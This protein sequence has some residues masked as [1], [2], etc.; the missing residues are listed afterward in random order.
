MGALTIVFCGFVI[1]IGAWVFLTAPNHKAV[2]LMLALTFGGLY[3]GWIE[4]MGRPIP[5]ITPIDKR[6]V[7]AFELDE[8]K[9]IYVWVREDEPRAYRL[10][11]DLSQAKELRRADQQAKITARELEWNPGYEEGE[12]QFYAKPVPEFPPKS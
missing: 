2:A 12:H 9:A 7:I 6:A 5:V 11:W 1:S 3:L 10:P 8:G 4:V